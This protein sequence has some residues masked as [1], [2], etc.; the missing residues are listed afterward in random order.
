MVREECEEIYQMGYKAGVKI[1]PKQHVKFGWVSLNQNRQTDTL[2]DMITKY[3]VQY[4]CPIPEF[5]MLDD[6]KE[7]GE[8]LTVYLMGIQNGSLKE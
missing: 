2:I 3:L 8:M 4:E 7:K 5:F 1:K 6:K